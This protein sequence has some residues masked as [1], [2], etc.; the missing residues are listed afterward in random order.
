[1]GLQHIKAQLEASKRRMITAKAYLMKEFNMDPSEL[2]VLIKAAFPAPRRPAGSG[3]SRN[4][5]LNGHNDETHGIQ[6]E[7]N[8]CQ[9]R[10]HGIQEAYERGKSLSYA[11]IQHGCFR[12]R[13]SH[14]RTVPPST[15]AS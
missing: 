1:M 2:E 6:E 11:R 8:A 3:K 14:Q 10:T 7:H 15:S 9:S 5:T 12:T 13:R 4:T